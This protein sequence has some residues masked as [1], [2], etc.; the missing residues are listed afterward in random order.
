MKNKKKIAAIIQARMGSKR[1]P[2][3]VMKK[4]CGK[5][6]I[7]LQIERLKKSKYIDEVILSTS[8]NPKDVKLKNFCERKLGINVF[9]GSEKNV[10]DRISKTIEKFKVDIHIECF[11]DS[12]LIDPKLIDEFILKFKRIK[13]DCLTNTL[14]TTY[15]PGQEILIC[16]G[17]K[18]LELN[19]IIKKKDPL[20]EHVGFNFTRFKKNFIIKN[21]VAP[22]KYNFPEIYLEIDKPIDLV[23]IKK[24]F[25]YFFKKKKIYFT[26][27]EIINFLKKND[28]LIKINNKVFRRWKLLR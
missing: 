14:K 25:K 1:F 27:E 12:P 6:I 2:G 19:K 20:R 26:L 16:N 28:K 10:L 9:V 7:Q 5:P 4:I 15:P 13:P 22:K 18:M 3:K 21:I 23:F 8:T 24:I 17:N 11:G